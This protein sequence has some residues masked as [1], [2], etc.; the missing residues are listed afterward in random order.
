MAQTLEY[1]EI[2]FKINM[3][4]ILDY[5]IENVCIKIWEIFSDRFKVQVLNRSS[6]SDTARGECLHEFISRQTQK[7]KSQ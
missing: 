7:M 3:I 2:N 5:P 6:R 1:S 4:N